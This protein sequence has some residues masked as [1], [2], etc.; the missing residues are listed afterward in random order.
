MLT[1]LTLCLIV[2]LIF[3]HQHKKEEKKE[4]K[5]AKIQLWKSLTESLKS[6]MLEEYASEPKSDNV[7]DEKANLFRKV[8]VDT[9]LQYEIKEFVY[10]KK[11]II[12]VL[13][14]YD[15]QKQIGYGPTLMG[16][17]PSRNSSSLAPQ[18]ANSPGHCYYLNML[19][20]NCFQCKQQASSTVNQMFQPFSPESIDS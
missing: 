5:N 11:K 3:P 1:N 19:L 9:L 8:V 16:A 17:G 4:E 20:A 6:K 15:Q 12:D 10:L 14:D 7:L 2:N 13:F 18:E